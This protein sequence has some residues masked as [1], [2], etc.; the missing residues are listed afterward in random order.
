MVMVSLAHILMEERGSWLRSKA[1][2][3]VDA[4]KAKAT[5]TT[6]ISPSRAT[7]PTA[8]T[9]S[10]GGATLPSPRRRVLSVSIPVAPRASDLPTARGVPSLSARGVSSLSAAAAPPARPTW[11]PTARVVSTGIE[12]TANGPR[13]ADVMRHPRDAETAP[14][15]GRKRKERT[16][17]DIY[18][19]DATAPDPERIAEFHRSICGV[20]RRGEEAAGANVSLRDAETGRGSTRSES[21]PKAETR[22]NVNAKAA[23]SQAAP[24]QAAPSLRR[25]RLRRLSG[26]SV[27]GGSVSGGSVSGGSVSGGSVSGGSVSG[28]S[29]SGGSVSGG[30]AAAPPSEGRD[31]AT[32]RAAG[33]RRRSGRRGGRRL[34]G[35]EE[36]VDDEGDE[37]DEGDAG[38]R[39]DGDGAGGGARPRV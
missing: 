24:S 2:A 34:A 25:L 7:L 6:T 22:S 1:Q 21:E 29:V 5:T 28:G 10:P 38:G 17:A 30:S 37:G 9:I 31:A 11:V 35:G 27:S 23:P 39:P 4:A 26:G 14:T 12:Q 16:L 13:N 3:A 15:L 36:K 33:G 8:T 19:V 18:A 32:E 20:F